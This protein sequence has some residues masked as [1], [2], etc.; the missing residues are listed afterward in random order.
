MNF[1]NDKNAFKPI[2]SP[3]ILDFTNC[4][5]IGEIHK[6]LKENFGLPDYYGENWDALWDCLRYLFYDEEDF[7]VELHSFLSLDTDFI[8]YC[9][10]MLEIFDDIHK[11][12][13]NF[14]YKIVS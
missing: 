7:L 13:P 2:K 6:I 14:T 11:E 9:T 4:K 3:V 12:C 8:D 5:H 10:P 1:E